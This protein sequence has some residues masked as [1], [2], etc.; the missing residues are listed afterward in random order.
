M[1]RLHN[2]I[3]KM[4]MTFL[5]LATASFD[6]SCLLH[7]YFSLPAILNTTVSGLGALKYIDKVW[8]IHY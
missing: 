8:M 4:F 5:F 2:I 7:T 1:N 6:F 3:I